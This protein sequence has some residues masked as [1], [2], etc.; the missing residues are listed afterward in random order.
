MLDKERA[1]G[2]LSKS[3]CPA[4]KPHGKRIKVEK[5]NLDLLEALK[6][7]LKAE[8]MV[9]H[10]WGGDRES[11]IKQVKAAIRRAEGR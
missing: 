6:A 10:D 9:S 8:W 1:K 2:A 3:D 4:I 7:L 5:I 11:V